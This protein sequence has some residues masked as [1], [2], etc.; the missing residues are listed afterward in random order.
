MPIQERRGATYGRRRADALLGRL[1]AGVIVMYLSLPAVGEFEGDPELL[2]MAAMALKDNVQRIATWQGSSLVEQTYED[3]EG[4]TIRE[5]S[6]FRF[7]FSREQEAT[8]WEWNGQKRY[9]REGLT[10]GGT[11]VSSGWT[12]N[13]AH[14][15]RKGDAFYK[16]DLGRTTQQGER[17]GTLVVW[18]ATRAERDVYS[19]SFDP[20][21]YL[22]GRATVDTDDLA[23]LIMFFY[24]QS[25]NPITVQSTARCKV[26]RDTN[27][28]I[29]D[30]RSKELLNHHVF[31]LSMGGC[32]IEYRGEGSHGLELRKW[33]YEQKDGAWVPKEFTLTHQ[34]RV[35]QEDGVTKFM[36]KVVFVENMVNHPVA[37]S[38]FSLATLG[39]KID[40][41]VSDHRS[42]LYYLYGGV[43]ELPLENADA[44]GAAVP[45]MEATSLRQRTATPEE[46]SSLPDV[47]VSDDTDSR[48]VGSQDNPS[49]GQSHQGTGVPVIL[50]VVL[51]MGIISFLLLRRRRK[52]EVRL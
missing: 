6:A 38:E 1:L 22:N 12:L 18:P 40:D 49:A 32:L 43:E 15:M 24:E 8:R 27:R 39:L 37:S 17:R 34:W 33:T 47:Q 48:Q 29:Y 5:S 2:K 7:I 44:L 14:E 11:P 9:V 35:P 50:A 45:A 42:G 26:V 10:R 16:Y 52:T 36:R 4:I 20:M 46:K 28:V 13:W 41:P 25:T 3:Q 30:I 23:R 19:Y 51:S 21:W 31:D